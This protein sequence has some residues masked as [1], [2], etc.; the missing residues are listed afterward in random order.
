MFLAQQGHDLA[1]IA[2]DGEDLIDEGICR[3]DGLIC[4][5]RQHMKFQI[6]QLLAKAS[7]DGGGQHDVANGTEAYEKDFFQDTIFVRQR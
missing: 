4:F 3:I 6:R 2:I 1:Q 7:N 5:F